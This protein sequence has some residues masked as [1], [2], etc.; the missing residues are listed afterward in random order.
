[1]WPAGP[2]ACEKK[3]PVIAS[4]PLLHYDLS[5]KRLASRSMPTAKAILG[6]FHQA[7]RPPHDFLVVWPPAH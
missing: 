6:I 4:V 7:G 5:Q 2:P 1:M 3:L